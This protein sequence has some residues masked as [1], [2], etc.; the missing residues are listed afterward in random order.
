MG[1]VYCIYS[2]IG[3]IYCTRL[4]V[5]SFLQ[6]TLTHVHIRGECCHAKKK[7]KQKKQLSGFFNAAWPPAWDEALR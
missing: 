3:L 5:H 4:T 1:S 2:L 7:T 6:T